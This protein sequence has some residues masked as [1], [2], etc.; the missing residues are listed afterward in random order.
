M[1]FFSFSGLYPDIPSYLAFLAYYKITYFSTDYEF[2]SYTRL[3]HI[4]KVLTVSKQTRRHLGWGLKLF[5]ILM[6]FINYLHI[7]C[8]LINRLWFYFFSVIVDTDLFHDEYAGN[9]CKVSNTQVTVM[10]QR[11]FVYS[12]HQNTLYK[13]Q[14]RFMFQ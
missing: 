7:D 6:T 5:I 3:S 13:N 1:N 11:S 14:S 10:D 2:I 4:I 8:Y 12:I 9:Q